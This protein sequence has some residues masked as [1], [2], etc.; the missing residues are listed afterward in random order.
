MSASQSP[1]KGS[2]RPHLRIKENRVTRPHR[3]HKDD[4]L[5]YPC[6]QCG[7]E[8]ATLAKANRHC[9]PLNKYER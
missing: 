5:Y 4:P 8:M 6:P 9:K 1:Y 2:S 3:K 7:V